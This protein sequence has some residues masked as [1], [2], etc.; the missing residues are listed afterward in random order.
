MFFGRAEQ[1][2]HILNR[3]PANYL[4]VG[5]RQLGKS[6]LLLA[7]K[8]RVE[9]RG[10]MICDYTSVGLNSFEAAIAPR[11]GLATDA[12]LADIVKVTC[13]ASPRRPRWFLLDESDAFIERDSNHFRVSGARRVAEP[14]S[15]GT[16]FL[17]SRRILE[18]VRGGEPGLFRRRFAI[19]ARL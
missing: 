10:D 13:A 11:L 8:R 5:A 4:I 17:H 16:L 2:K 14:D 3:D 1:L 9:Q 18:A 12:S 19:S 7:I 6:S 15:R